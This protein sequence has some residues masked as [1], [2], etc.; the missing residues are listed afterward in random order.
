MTQRL[1]DDR[2]AWLAMRD[3]CQKQA[4]RQGPFGWLLTLFAGRSTGGVVR[5]SGTDLTVVSNSGRDLRREIRGERMM[6]YS[7]AVDSCAQRLTAEERVALRSA[8]QLPEWF[9]TAV[10]EEYTAI[11][12]R[13]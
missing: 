7:L 3:Y 11:R 12:K 10:N 2:L 9:V 1:S 6:D 8:G 4:R 13:R 5:S